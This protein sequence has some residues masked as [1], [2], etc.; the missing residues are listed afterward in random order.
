MLYH[1]LAPLQNVFGPF[2]LFRYVTFRAA[3]AGALAIVL[4]LLLGPVLI[5]LVR[6]LQIGQNVREEVPERHREKAGTPTMG[7]ALILASALSGIVLFADLG[8][9]RVLI[10]LGVLVALGLLGMWDDYVKVRGGRARG[11]NK[12]TKLLFQ[13]LV[14][15]GVAALLY[16]FPADP[17]LR[18]CT[19]LPVFEK[20]I[21]DFRWFYIPLV[22]LLIVGFSNAVNLADGL[23]GLAPSLLVIS[24]GGYAV[25]AYVAGALL[26]FS[27]YQLKLSE[28][29]RV[30]FVPGAG[31]MTVYCLAVA[32]ACLGFLWFNAYPAQIFMGDTGSLPLGGALAYAAV[33]CKQELLLPLVGGVFVLEAVSVILQVGYFR[34]TRGGRLFRMAPVHHHFE[35]LG[36]AEPKVVTRFTIVAALLAMLA[37]ATLKVR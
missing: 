16:R 36:W 27:S 3:M 24:F 8:N 18:T 2:R 5:R 23:D 19:N 12:R 11:V 34:A 32:G 14:A 20:V 31:E 28:Y 30:L 13:F 22:M 35:L 37:V 1:L 4:V 7:G 25:L 6:R 29:L 9:A 17:N 21:I 15:A 10:G 26:T 33:V